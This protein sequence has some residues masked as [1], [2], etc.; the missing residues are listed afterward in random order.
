M[1]QHRT[2]P[3]P[4]HGQSGNPLDWRANHWGAVHHWNNDGGRRRAVHTHT[5]TLT[6]SP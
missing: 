6:L 3:V 4:L 1:Y 5:L 2:S